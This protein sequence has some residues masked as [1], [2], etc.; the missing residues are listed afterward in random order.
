MGVSASTMF[1]G[2][3]VLPM[4]EEGF[5]PKNLSKGRTL[6]G[7]LAIRPVDRKTPS[8]GCVAGLVRDRLP[9]DPVERNGVMPAVGVT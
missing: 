9:L 8:E 5:P 2:K 7:D 4:D 1:R 6:E 3:Q